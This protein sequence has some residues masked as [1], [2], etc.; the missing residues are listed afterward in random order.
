MNRR[1][2]II[3]KLACIFLYLYLY[4]YFSL[5][6]CTFS[7]E[8]VSSCFLVVTRETVIITKNIYVV[9]RWIA[10][11]F[12]CRKKYLHI[13]E[14]FC[15]VIYTDLQYFFQESFVMAILLVFL[16]KILYFHRAFIV[17][18]EVY[19]IHRE[20]RNCIQDSV[21]SFKI[22]YFLGIFSIFVENLVFS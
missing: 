15:F 20:F 8:K 2:V 22:L 5:V 3:I 12:P 4:W 16:L 18:L 19:Y 6:S 13:F 9:V 7:R 10:G 17:M 21:S 11:F 1:T 14:L